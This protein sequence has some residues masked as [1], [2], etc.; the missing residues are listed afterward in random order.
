[1]SRV[2]PA[3]SKAPITRVDGPTERPSL[4]ACRKI[5][6][7][8]MQN[9]LVPNILMGTPVNDGVYPYMVAIATSSFGSKPAFSC[10]G[11]L[12]S[13]RFVLSAAHCFRNT[14]VPTF[15]RLGTVNLVNPTKRY[16]DIGVRNY[17]THPDYVPRRK[18]NDIALL[19]LEREANIAAHSNIYPVCLHTDPWDL[20]VS[21][22]LFVAGWG[23][24]NVHNRSMSD[25]LLRA[26]LDLVPR[27]KCNE[28]Y[29]VHPTAIYSLNRGVIDSLICAGD[30][31]QHKADSCQGD[32]GGPL[33]LNIHGEENQYAIVGIISSGFGCATN[34]PALYTR[35]ASFL[36]YIESIVWPENVL[37]TGI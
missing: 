20:P 21:S 13:S 33:I 36:D 8:R 3:V 15:V 30:T 23:V 6:S 4:V 18:Y 34:T 27:D 10:G 17:S 1:M 25:V 14:E 32:S 24:T 2:R 11:S 9:R 22:K 12:I 37:G 5:R 29:A 31:K 35:V 7:E 16:Q 28:S 19:E 26:S